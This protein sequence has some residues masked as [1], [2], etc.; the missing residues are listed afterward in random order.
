MII[1]EKYDVV[2]IGAGPAGSVAAR[3]AAENGASVLILERDREPG[4]PVRCAEGVSHKGIEP[5][6]E[7][8]RRWIAS[9]IDIAKLQAPNGES[10]R[11]YSNGKGYVLERRIFDTA[12]CEVACQHGADLLTKA[13]ALDLVWDKD[14]IV[15]VKYKYLDEIKTVQC[16]IVIGAD[17]VE[18]RV[19]RWAGIDTKVSMD[20]IETA[21]QY[22]LSDIEVE[23]KTCEF[24]FGNQVAPKGYVW[25]FPKSKNSAN[26][27]IGISGDM[28][29]EKGPKYY[30]DKFVN[31]RFPRATVTYTVYGGVPTAWGL[32][33]IVRD[34][35]MLVGDAARQVNPISGGG[36]VQGMIA[37]E[38]CGKVASAAVKKNKFDAKTL[39]VYRKDWDKR[40]GNNQKVIHAMKNKFMTMKDSEFNNLMKICNS[41]PPEKFTVARLFKEAVRDDPKLV[42]Q[43][44]KTFI[45]AK[46]K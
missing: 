42:M 23:E 3:F 46:F 32:D 6:I 20:D 13:D 25:I 2:V 17:G 38:L 45:T 28:A 1:K 34:N 12:L 16:K 21:V 40:L 33:E 8:D 19:G 31:E 43:V 10:T 39:K 30:L 37:G 35:I 5:Y 41:I 26:V 11:M 14:Q 24:Y 18:S 7:I 4:I 9:D 44:A 27:G 22:T 36:I 15:G 29:A